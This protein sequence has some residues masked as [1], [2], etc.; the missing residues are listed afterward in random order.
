MMPAWAKVRWAKA[1]WNKTRWAK[2]R[3]AKARFLLDQRLIFVTVIFLIL[4][5]GLSACSSDPDRKI[6]NFVTEVKAQK[7]A[8]IEKLPKFAKIEPYQYTAQHLRSPF[9]TAELPAQKVKPKQPA[10]L[11]DANRPK[12]ILE[13]FPL[14]SLKMVGTLQRGGQVWALIKDPH[15]LVYRVGIGNHMGL[16]YGKI[17]KIEEKSMELQEWV[18]DSNGDYQKRNIHIRLSE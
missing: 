12:E 7:S 14:D 3:W 10:P 13:A 5:L 18:A 9:E 8:G 16:N 15:G 4:L 2:A 11:P 6:K 17:E 1:P